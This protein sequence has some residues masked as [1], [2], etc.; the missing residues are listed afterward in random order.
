MSDDEAI[1]E[2][3]VFEE[4]ISREELIKEHLSEIDAA[5]EEVGFFGRFSRMMKGLGKPRSSAEYKLARTELQR[6]VAPMLAVLCPILRFLL[7]RSDEDNLCRAD[8]AEHKK[9]TKHNQHGQRKISA[10]IQ[11]GLCAGGRKKGTAAPPA[12]APGSF[13]DDFRDPLRQ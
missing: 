10:G 4:E 6:L 5:F 2:E 1:G 11:R 12:F 8:N 3:E 13:V 9:N 7:L